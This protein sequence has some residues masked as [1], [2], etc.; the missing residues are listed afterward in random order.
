VRRIEGSI[1]GFSCDIVRRS[2]RAH[3]A[4]RRDTT[5]PLDTLQEERRVLRAPNALRDASS[6][7]SHAERTRRVVT[8]IDGGDLLVLPQHLA[9]P[10]APTCASRRGAGEERRSEIQVTSDSTG[11]KRWRSSLLTSRR[12]VDEIFCVL[13]TSCC[14]GRG[15]STDHAAC[16]ED[17]AW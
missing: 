9:T 6:R 1:G 16:D 12:Y 15:C 17:E 2:D 5:A 14:P 7:Q 13:I 8:D 4:R 3:P 10:A 11:A